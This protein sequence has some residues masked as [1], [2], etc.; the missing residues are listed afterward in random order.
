MG[1]TS[2][3]PDNRSY[4]AAEERSTDNLDTSGLGSRVRLAIRVEKS[5]YKQLEGAAKYR[6]ILT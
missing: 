3:A 4:M 5:Q 1:T 2:Q 6:N